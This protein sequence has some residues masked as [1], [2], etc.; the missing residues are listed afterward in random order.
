MGA[1]GA[2][3]AAAGARAVGSLCIGC[4]VCQA[5]ALRSLRQAAH[6]VAADSRPGLALAARAKNHWFSSWN[7]PR[8]F[9]SIRPEGSSA[10][11]VAACDG[12][13]A[14]APT[15]TAPRAP[16]SKKKDLCF[17]KSSASKGSGSN[18]SLFPKPF[19]FD[20][21]MFQRT[22][23]TSAFFLA[24]TLSSNAQET[25]VLRYV[26]AKDTGAKLFNLADKASIVVGTVPAKGLLEVYAENAGY[27]S[28]DAP[29]GMEV[30]VYGQYLRTTAVPGIVEVN[31]NGVFMRPLPK[32]DD[33]SYPL[34]QQLHKGDRL[35]VLGRNDATKALAADWVKV[36]SPAGTR[37][38]VVT[39][40]TTAVD[41]KEDVRTAWADAVKSANASRPTFDL[42][43]AKTQGAAA[44]VAVKDAAADANEKRTVAWAGADNAAKTEGAQ[45]EGTKAEGTKAAGTQA[46]G[47]RDSSFES[48]ERLYEASRT[49]STPDWN[50]V[51]AAYQR[52]LEANP[53]GTF[54]D[55]ARLQLQKVELHEEIVRIQSERSRDDSTRGDRLASARARLA[56]VSQGDNPLWGRFQARG[57]ILRE[58]PVASDAPRFIVYWAGRPQAEIVCSSGRYDLA[59]FADYEVGISGAVLRQAVSGSDSSGARPARIDATKIEVLG[60][61]SVAR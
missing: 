26:R 7:G 2:G 55:K 25:G 21:T 13:S 32:S 35:K 22:V 56:E 31:G 59:K 23:I 44:T 12:G 8:R 38:W 51:R 58:Q 33:S 54:A 48:A 36:V 14:H 42:T 15:N 43:A 29:G 30:W 39:D 11:F 9:P 10:V 4:E 47:A 53:K 49:S 20:H 57:W 41:T 34:Q 45:A 1:G 27:L 24:L 17:E 6:S 28:V 46:S 40:D 37:A 19:D 3:L 16:Y 18:G 60:A 61:R 5:R 52:Y 50:G